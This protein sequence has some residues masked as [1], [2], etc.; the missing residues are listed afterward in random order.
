MK[1]TFLLNGVQRQEEV[2]PRER[3]DAFLRRLGVLSIRNGCNGEG[4][5]GACAV[6]FDGRLV[7]SCILLAAQLDG[8]QVCTVEF[9]SKHRTLSAIQSALVDIGVVQCGYCSAALICA[10]EE[11]LEAH[12][13]PSD[14][15]IRD[16]LSGIFCP[17]FVSLP[18]QIPPMQEKR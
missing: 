9:Y 17:P 8:H 11:L 5:C 14:E 2:E 12:P 7:N 16:A 13:D 6:R 4:T 18:Y 15:E 10:I 3:A 1:I